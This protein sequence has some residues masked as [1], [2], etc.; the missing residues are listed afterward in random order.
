MF[1]TADI[2]AKTAVFEMETAVL[3]LK[4]GVFY[5]SS[6]VVMVI[7]Y[8]H[9]TGLKLNAVN[10]HDVKFIRMFV[11][12]FIIYPMRIFIPALFHTQNWLSLKSEKSYP[13]KADKVIKFL[14]S[15]ALEVYPVSPQH[16]EVNLNSTQFEELKKAVDGMKNY[17][18][19]PN[20]NDF[21]LKC[22]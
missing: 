11:F 5:L 1:E 7:S 17:R 13:M 2:A 22:F 6:P 19:K 16:V 21:T 4:T 9:S 8:E 12:S 14:R 10:F 20:S 18:L 15:Q 3:V